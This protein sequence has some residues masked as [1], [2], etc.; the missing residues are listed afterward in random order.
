[1]FFFSSCAVFDA[2]KRVAGFST[3]KFEKEQKGR[4]SQDFNLTK[5]ESFDRSLNI[6]KSLRARVTSKSYKKGYIVAF[7]FSKSF[8]YCLD[9]TEAAFYIEE[10]GE[11]SVKV[12]VVCNNSLL[13][14]NL[15]EK[16]FFLMLNPPKTQE[17]E[18]F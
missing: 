4:Y 15:S 5:K 2:P 18:L 16:F 17:D 9:S 13:A 14:Q 8:D 1:M 3:Q 10:T 7:D 11:N 12:T 6:I